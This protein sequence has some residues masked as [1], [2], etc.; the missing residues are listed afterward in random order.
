MCCVRVSTSF[1]GACGSLQ[2]RSG[3]TECGLVT[4]VRLLELEA[5][6]IAQLPVF[7]DW[8]F[9]CFLLQ[10]RLKSLTELELLAPPPPSLVSK[11]ADIKLL[12]SSGVIMTGVI[13]LLWVWAN[14]KSLYGSLVTLEWSWWL[15]KVC[16][17]SLTPSLVSPRASF[18]PLKSVHDWVRSLLKRLRLTFSSESDAERFRRPVL[19]LHV[20]NPW[21]SLSH[22]GLFVIIHGSRW[23]SNSRRINVF[24]PEIKVHMFV[25]L[26]PVW[27]CWG[28]ASLSHSFCVC[29]T[30]SC[31]FFLLLFDRCDKSLSH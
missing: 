15:S 12:F 20:Q 17:E 21:E 7:Y 4:F 27:V 19:Q 26:F 18:L 24:A 11:R 13:R 10:R 22:T 2:A 28:A 9:F 23:I 29:P 31:I 6:R 16:E 8:F 30:V 1:G 5:E 14:R 25:F 3:G